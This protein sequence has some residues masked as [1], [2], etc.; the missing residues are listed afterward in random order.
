MK[1]ISDKA[2]VS[3]DFPDKAYMGSF[4]KESSFDVKVEPDEVL[5]RIVR[6]G[7]ERRE[8][9]VHLHYFLLA[10]ILS[11]I[12]QGL[13]TQDLDQTHCEVMREGADALAKGL[14]KS[15]QRFKKRKTR[16]RAK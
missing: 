1:T 12:G 13:A 14:A 15:I 16:P 5:V 3:V 11:E 6:S 10:D 8:V 2:E 7:A 9:A 4:G